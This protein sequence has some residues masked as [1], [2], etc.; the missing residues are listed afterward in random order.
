MKKTLLYLFL[1]ISLSL[2]FL[3]DVDAQCA[4]CKAT[5]ESASENIDESIGEGLNNGILYLMG[6]PYVLMLLAVLVFFR[7]HIKKFYRELA[8]HH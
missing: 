3:G 4:M 7:K 1:L 5:A 2:F 6:I 8:H